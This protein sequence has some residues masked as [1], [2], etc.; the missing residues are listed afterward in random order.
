MHLLQG[1]LL[2]AVPQQRDPNFEQT[3]ILVVKHSDQ[4]TFGL[5]LNC[6]RKRSDGVLCQSKA[7]RRRC[8][9]A[10]LY[11]GGPVTGPLMA[12]HCHPG[13]GEIEIL[14]GLFF[15][16]SEENVLA[17]LKRKQQPCRIFAGYAGWG[18][19]QLDDEIGKGAWRTVKA[20]AERVFSCSE[21]LW[22]DLHSEA[23]RTMCQTTFHLRT[24]LSACAAGASCA[25]LALPQRFAEAWPVTAGRTRMLW[26]HSFS[27]NALRPLSAGH[28]RRR[29]GT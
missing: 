23:L 9:K 16:G 8:K 2:V 27:G 26:P 4:G 5:I 24:F 29:N 3:V 25:K 15:S 13:L 22:L 20:T 17:V 19:K 12:V 11:Y 10:N 18:P 28:D 21:D 7:G 1:H 14:P 6:P